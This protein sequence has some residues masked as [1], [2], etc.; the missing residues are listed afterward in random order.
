[1]WRNAIIASSRTAASSTKA[2]LKTASPCIQIAVPSPPQQQR[3]QS[4]LPSTGGAVASTEG[5]IP[6][7][8][9]SPLDAFRDSVTRDA[10]MN[11]LVGRSWTVKELRRKSFDDLHS[12]WFVLYKEYNMLLTEANLS[13]RKGL[14]FPQPERKVKVKK[15][16]GAIKHV[17]GERKRD[18]VSQLEAKR[19]DEE[20]D[21]EEEELK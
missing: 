21:V 7:H 16:M 20:E 15:S 5:K 19:L 8:G 9:S 17:L 14:V 6:N 10:R 2:A 12:L 11:E 3:F 18:F 1:M 13:R 4:S